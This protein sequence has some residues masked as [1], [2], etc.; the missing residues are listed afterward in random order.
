MITGTKVAFAALFAF[1][2]PATASAACPSYANSGAPLSYTAESA[3]MPQATRVVAGGNIDLSQC[4]EVPGVGF[5][6][7]S[8]DFTM[9]YDALTLGRALELRV[10]GDCDTV[11]LVNTAQ[12]EWV[13]NDDTNGLNPAVRIANAPSGQYDIWVGTLGSDTCDAQL[14]VE[15]F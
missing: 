1:A 15:T 14:E 3:Y 13:F 10:T 8:P 9:M 4:G 5:V 6:V 11:L 2:L 7:E 12:G